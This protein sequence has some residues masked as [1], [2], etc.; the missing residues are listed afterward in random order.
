MSRLYPTVLVGEEVT[1]SDTV[2]ITRNEYDMLKSN[3][4]SDTIT[5]NLSRYDYMKDRSEM[6]ELV[7]TILAKKEFCEDELRMILGV[8]KTEVANG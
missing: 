3:D 2:I 7:C 6:L 1:M 8:E 4:E 5:I